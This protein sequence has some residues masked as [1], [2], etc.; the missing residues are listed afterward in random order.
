MKI[1]VLAGLLEKPANE[2]V[3]ALNVTDENDELSEE[4]VA[5]QLKGFIDSKI[6]ETRSKAKDEGKGWGT[7]EAFKTVTSKL[8]G[9]GLDSDDV[10]SMI[11]ELSTKLNST[12]GQDEKTKRQLE[13]QKSKIDELTGTITKMNN[14]RDFEKKTSIIKSKL[15]PILSEFEGTEKAKQLALSTYLNTVTVEIDGED[16]NILEGEGKYSKKTFDEHSLDYFSEL[17]EKKKTGNEPPK[18]PD[19]TK[20]KPK[21]SKSRNDLLIDLRTA[22]TPE[23][24]ASI[25]EAINSLDKN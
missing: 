3:T 24:R 6:K 20:Q 14:E 25:Q 12:V 17:F 15:N 19:S 23:E 11:D 2:L 13:L 5:E 8:K 4:V 9:L 21:T 22:K 16:L 10:D 7:K 18:N 1:G